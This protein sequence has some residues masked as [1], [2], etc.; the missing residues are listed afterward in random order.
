MTSSPFE[1]ASKNQRELQ[2]S[3]P[4]F[5]SVWYQS[6]IAFMDVTWGI[7]AFMAFQLNTQS[8]KHFIITTIEIRVKQF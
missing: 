4:L 6:L 3:V 5:I 8:L 1:A 7:E 2:I